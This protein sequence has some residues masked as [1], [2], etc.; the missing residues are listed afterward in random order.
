MGGDI[1]MKKMFFFTLIG[2]L[3]LGI[4]GCSKTDDLS[5]QVL[6]E[7]NEIH[8]S[9]Y[10]TDLHYDRYYGSYSGGYVFFIEA[11]DFRMKTV[12]IDGLSFSGSSSW[13]L[14]LFSNKSFYN[15]EDYEL[16]IESGLLTHNDLFKIHKAHIEYIGVSS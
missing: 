1:V 6:N 8:N 4:F 3:T 15:I 11:D 5:K 16:L 13:K 14:I 9:L 10:G 2:V 7:I 12:L